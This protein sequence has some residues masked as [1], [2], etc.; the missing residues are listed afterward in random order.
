[1]PEC[2]SMTITCDPKL[3]SIHKEYILDINYNVCD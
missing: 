1:M 2:C 3:T